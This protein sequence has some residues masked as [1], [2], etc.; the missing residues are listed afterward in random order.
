MTTPQCEPALS[1][2]LEAASAR[3][4]EIY[5]GPRPV[6]LPTR[7]LDGV[8]ITPLYRYGLPAKAPGCWSV[9]MTRVGLAR[10]G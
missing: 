3:I 6:S 9:F 5:N 1:Q 4:A 2:V 8:S 10:G 7:T